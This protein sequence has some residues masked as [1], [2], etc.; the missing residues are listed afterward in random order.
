MRN[1]KIDAILSRISITHQHGLSVRAEIDSTRKK[2]RELEA[3]EVRLEQLNRIRRREIE[4]IE[5]TQRKVLMYDSTDVGE[6]PNNAKAVAGYVGGR[7]PTFRELLRKFRHAYHISIAISAA[8]NAE[9]LDIENGDAIPQEAPGWVRRQKSRG[10]RRPILYANL[11]TMPA[12]ILY[13]KRAGIALSEVR[14]WVAHYTGTPHIPEGF[15]AC[16]FEDNALGRNLDAS[17]CNGDFFS[18]R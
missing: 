17:L 4:V 16:Q 9:C 8:E 1:P 11:S 6:I 15:D 5:G 3:Y 7:W 10:I 2:L 18:D 14:L 13:L 12:V